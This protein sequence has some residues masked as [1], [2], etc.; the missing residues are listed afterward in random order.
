MVY[1]PSKLPTYVR[2]MLIFPAGFVSFP[3][4]QFFYIAFINDLA[5]FHVAKNCNFVI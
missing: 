3:M 1:F 5:T 4:S 2:E